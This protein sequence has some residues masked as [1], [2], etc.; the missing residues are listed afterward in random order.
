M[1]TDITKKIFF[2]LALVAF[3]IP[4]GAQGISFTTEKKIG[5]TIKLKING[6]GAV[7]ATGV[8]EAITLGSSDKIYTLTDKTVTLNGD[9]TELDCGNNEL[10][11]LNVTKSPKLTTLECYRNKLT[12]LD[13]TE[14]ENLERLSCNDNQLTSITLSKCVML[15]NLNCTKNS[16]SSVDVSNCQNLSV[17]LCGENELTSLDMSNHL[18]LQRLSCRKNKL[19]NLSV[20]RCPELTT[21]YCNNNQLKALDVSES[22][23]MT[24][25]EC[26][27]NQLESLNLSQCVALEEIHCYSNKLKTLDLPKC[28][29]LLTLRCEENNFECE[30][31]DKIA[32]TL[33][34]ADDE[35][36]AVFVV[37]TDAEINAAKKQGVNVITKHA[38]DVAKGKNWNV[39]SVP[40]AGAGT[41]KRTRYA[42]LEGTCA[43]YTLAEN[44]ITFVTNK[45]VG[46]TVIL[47]IEGTGVVTATG[48]KEAVALGSENTYTLTDKTVTLKGNVTGLNCDNNGLTS[49]IVTSTELKNLSCQENQLTSLDKFECENLTKFFCRKNQIAKL[50]LSH[51]PNL[52]EMDCGKNKLTE[53]DVSGCPKLTTLECYFNKLT[54]L[55][56]TKCENL[57]VLMC[58]DNSLTSIDVSKCTK[59]R[60]LNCSRNKLSTIDVSKCQDLSSLL[61]AANQLTSLDMSNYKKL[62]MLACRKNKL[63]FLAAKQCPEL[64]D[65]S[66]DFNQLTS[67]DVSGCRKMTDIQCSKNQLESLNLSQCT[68]LQGIYCYSNKL[69][70][71]DI[72]MCP[73]LVYL[74]CEE[75][76]FG[77]EAMEKIANALP[78]RVDADFALFIVATAAEINAAEKQGVNVITKHAVDIAQDKTWFV[79][80]DAK[81]G[82][83]TKTRTEYAG[84]DGTCN[85]NVLSFEVT[86]SKSANGQIVI[87]GADDLKAVP[88]GKELTVEVIPESGYKLDKLMANNEDITSSKRFVV[89]SKVKIR[90]TFTT[91]AES[92]VSPKP[93]LFPN[94]ANS[95][96]TLL[97][98]API[99]QVRIYGTDGILLQTLT[100]DAKG[101]VEI[102]VEGF[103]EGSYL[104]VFRNESGI[105]DTQQLTIKR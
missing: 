70:T 7:T 37:V 75:N 88:Y 51:W 97:G 96:A 83:A 92:I 49:L 50:D 9:V 68:D 13:L 100:S 36:Y 28:P 41:Q 45:Q 32:N 99:S 55:D 91:G 46:E 90:A 31:M 35:D 59:L 58:Y 3:I 67:L 63:T 73:S 101:K 56:L 22:K 89:R 103:A 30:A 79:F 94:P 25:I 16:L 11:A 66:C 47:K 20:K 80:S 62:T 60:R 74:S 64:T 29:R 1:K 77:C 44:S 61:C 87:K 6:T 40:Q 5:E 21:L 34:T 57:E 85:G 53:L 71:L 38:V 105:M 86:V 42:G 48:L 24:Y 82:T 76:N 39:F 2:L 14:C 65:L 98:T 93:S 102:C 8:K 10:T 54:S 18:K 81:A 69:T 12:S 84:Y 95:K 23:K 104:V 17:L 72:S 15:V 33:P 26:S 52:E 19:T 4:A 43:D 78:N 27:N